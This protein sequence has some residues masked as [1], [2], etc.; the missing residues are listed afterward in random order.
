MLLFVL[1]LCLSK[2]NYFYLSIF[3]VLKLFQ[4]FIIIIIKLETKRG[5][6]IVIKLE[7]KRGIIIVIKLETTGYNYRNKIRNYRL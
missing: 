6:I 5:I 2:A 7:T 4:Q 3:N 1:C